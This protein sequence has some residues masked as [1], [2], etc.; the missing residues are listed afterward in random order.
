MELTQVRA[1]VPGYG[2]GCIDTS[3]SAT[4]TLVGCWDYAACATYLYCS[5]VFLTG[6]VC[7]A[8]NLETV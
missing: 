2:G 3:I 8:V 4:S 1:L 7:T 5:S 6:M